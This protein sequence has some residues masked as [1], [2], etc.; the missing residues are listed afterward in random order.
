M[1]RGV[2]SELGVSVGVGITGIAGPS[3][4]TRKKPV[5]LVYVSIADRKK[6]RTIELNLPGERERIR[7]YAANRALALIW[8]WI[9]TK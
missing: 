1:A 2:R 9:Q 3:G 6:S 5:G 8:E 4:G 7:T